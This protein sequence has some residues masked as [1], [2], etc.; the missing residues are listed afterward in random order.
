MNKTMQIVPDG[1]PLVPDD[2]PSLDERL[3][4]GSA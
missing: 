1:P 3:A 4:L 2:Q